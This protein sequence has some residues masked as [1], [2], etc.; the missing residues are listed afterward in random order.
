MIYWKSVEAFFS[1]GGYG[2]MNV[3]GGG[4]SEAGITA[5]NAPPNRLLSDRA[6]TNP[7]VRQVD[8]RIRAA[9]AVAPWGMQNGFWDAAGLD[10]VKTPVLFVAG[11]ADSVAGYEKGTRA[12][13]TGAVRADRYLLTF[14]DA[15]HNAGIATVTTMSHNQGLRCKAMMIQPV[16]FTLTESVARV[17]KDASRRRLIPTEPVSTLKNRSR[18]CKPAAA[19][20]HR[21]RMYPILWDRSPL[22][23]L[24][25]LSTVDGVNTPPYVLIDRFDHKSDR[26]VSKTNVHTTGVFAVRC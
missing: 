15:N 8:P 10:G 6:A 11:S 17:K 23:Q 1:M 20:I 19:Q 5:N 2:L 13:F 22:R 3:I 18:F 7:R 16:R 9:I 12:L 25:V 4:Y 14:V 26:S 24:N 21:F